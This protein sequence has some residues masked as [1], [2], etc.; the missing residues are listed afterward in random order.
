MINEPI[1]G[2][3]NKRFSNQPLGTILL[4]KGSGDVIGITEIFA[5][6]NFS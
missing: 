3:D 5:S 2:R 4:K 6:L 1:R